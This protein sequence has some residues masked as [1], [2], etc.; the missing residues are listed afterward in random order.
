VK[1]TY[2]LQIKYAVVTILKCDTRSEL[3]HPCYCYFGLKESFRKWERNQCK[4]I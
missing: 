4:S 1:F 2:L 3:V